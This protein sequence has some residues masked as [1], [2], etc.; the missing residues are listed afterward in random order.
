MIT[1][2]QIIT[3]LC[4]I[5]KRPQKINNFLLTYRYIVSLTTQKRDYSIF[6]HMNDWTTSP[7]ITGNHSRSVWIIHLHQTGRAWVEWEK[8]GWVLPVPEPWK[9][10]ADTVHS[11]LKNKSIHSFII[12]IIIREY[13][14]SAH[15]LFIENIWTQLP[16][17]QRGEQQFLLPLEF[18]GG[19]T[20][21]TVIYTRQKRKEKL[22]PIPPHGSLTNIG[23]TEPDERQERKT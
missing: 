23:V 16:S 12:I 8:W 18:G 14:H 7:F 3:I 6:F 4:N 19:R 20:N 15:S 17:R 21:R 10:V 5:S 11:A 22:T 1:L 9:S 13:T 2:S